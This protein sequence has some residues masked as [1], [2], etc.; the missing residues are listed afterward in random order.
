[1][2]SVGNRALVA[3]RVCY[4]K[5]KTG[6]SDNALGIVGDS[7]HGS[8]YHLGRDRLSGRLDPDYSTRTAPRQGGPD[9]RR[10]RV[11]PG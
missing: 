3:V 8:G 4:L 2:A 10:E 9:Q 5:P 11:R 6:L 1:M 7:Q